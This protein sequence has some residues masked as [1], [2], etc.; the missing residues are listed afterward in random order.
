MV[1][2]IILGIV[3]LFLAVLLIRA[4]TFRPKAQPALSQ[5]TVNVDIDTAV[6]N[7]QQLVQ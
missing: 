2:W 5:E 3:L 6:S 4:A 1:G 7:L